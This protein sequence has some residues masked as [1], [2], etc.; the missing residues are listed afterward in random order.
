MSARSR[1]YTVSFMPDHSAATLARFVARLHGYEP[2]LADLVV[3]FLGGRHVPTEAD[4]DADDALRFPPL[5]TAVVTR[6][7]LPTSVRAVYFPVSGMGDT[8]FKP[9]EVWP[10]KNLTH[11]D[12][13]ARCR[14][15]PT[16]FTAM[17]IYSKET[18]TIALPTTIQQIGAHAFGGLFKWKTHLN[19][20]RLEDVG[21]GAFCNSGLVSAT[22]PAVA[23]I[24]KAAFYSTTLRAITMAGAPIDRIPEYCFYACK[25]LAE[26]ELSDATVAVDKGAFRQCSAIARFI[27]R[28]VT[29][30]HRTAFAASQHNLERLTGCLP[31]GVHVEGGEWHH[32]ERGT[33]VVADGDSAV[34]GGAAAL[35]GLV[36]DE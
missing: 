9:F 4:V 13:G 17:L 19:L 15:V 8:P 12:V 24:G 22:L 16:S 21:R 11:V 33:L 23:S 2:D 3:W 36:V 25:S 6:V 20:P 14:V 34:G 1:E 26:V 30:V 31:G 29:T 28:E 10:L 18:L 5:K 35:G 32:L 7:L 27:G